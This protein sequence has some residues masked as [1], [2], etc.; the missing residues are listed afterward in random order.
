MSRARR[1]HEGAARA[2]VFVTKT[3]SIRWSA[4]VFVTKTSATDQRLSVSRWVCGPSA[5]ENDV[6]SS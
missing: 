1:T 2:K 3:R 6:T 5:V 4:K